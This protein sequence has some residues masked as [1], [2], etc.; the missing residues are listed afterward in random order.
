MGAILGAGA[1]AGLGAVGSSFLGSSAA[2]KAAAQQAAAIREATAE[3]RR[4][5]NET[6]G[7]L[8][9]YTK[10][11]GEQLNELGNWLQ[12]PVKQ[13]MNYLD[14]GY[15]FRRSE[16][17]KGLYG[18]AGTSGLLQSGDTLRAAERYGQGLAS[19]EYGNAF[20]RWLGEGQYRQGLAGMG[21]SAAAQ[22]G[23][24]GQQSA[25]AISDLLT[26][27][28][29]ADAAG[30]LGAGKAWSD[31][32][33]G[34]GGLGGNLLAKYFQAQKTPTQ[35]T[36]T[37]DVGVVPNSMTRDDPA[38]LGNYFQTPGGSNTVDWSTGYGT[39]TGMGAGGG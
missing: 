39:E 29:A 14:P 11:G 34:L 31:L 21:Q 6:V 9:P 24:F 12:D 32:S 13:P 36:P 33:S 17:M 23:Y 1:I 4:Q 16:G 26:K 19:S 28:G 22:Q 5:Y 15:E 10:F 25:N 2:K 3:Q 38:W 18:N 30:T 37:S 27:G 8:Q 20:N 35:K 7:R